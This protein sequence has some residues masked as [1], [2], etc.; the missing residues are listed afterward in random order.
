MRLRHYILTRY[1][2]GLYERHID[3]AI[4]MP[5]RLRLFRRYCVPSIRAQT[6]QAFDWLVA[7]D[8]RTSQA[9]RRQIVEAAPNARIIVNQSACTLNRFWS[10]L[11]STFATAAGGCDHVLTTRLDNDDMFAV[12]AVEALQT[13]CRRNTRSRALDFRDNLFYHVRNKNHRYVYIEHENA[14]GSAF[15]SYLEPCSSRCHT[16]LS[17]RHGAWTRP[18]FVATQRTMAICHRANLGNRIRPHY[19]RRK[20]PRRFPRPNQPTLTTHD[21]TEYDQDGH[22]NSGENDE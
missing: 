10:A 6:C 5:Y 20:W 1:N 12:D 11:V 14:V 9:D 3:P 21:K 8:T 13:A 18:Q 19:K 17:R 22:A 2:L 4:W 15:V 7:I 16:V